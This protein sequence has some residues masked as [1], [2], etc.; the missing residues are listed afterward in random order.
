MSKSRQNNWKRQLYCFLFLLVMGSI[1]SISILTYLKS[2]QEQRRKFSEQNQQLLAQLADNLN[3]YFDDLLRFS[4]VP[5][6]NK[7]LINM[8]EQETKVEA[9]YRLEKQRII[10]DFLDTMMVYP[11]E[12][13]Q[14]VLLIADQVYYGSRYR[15]GFKVSFSISDMDESLLKQLSREGSAFFL[16][17]Y[18]S[19]LSSGASIEIVSLYNVVYSAINPRKMLAI[20]R[21][22]ADFS[23]IDRACSSIRIGKNS[24]VVI[25]GDEGKIAFSSAPKSVTAALPLQV[26]NFTA[27]G[28]IQ[29]AGGDYLINYVEITKP[30]WTAY[31]VTSLRD[32]NADA[33]STRNLMLASALILATITL[34]AIVLSL[35]RFLVPLS[36]IMIRIR[37]VG[38]GNFRVRFPDKRDDEIGMLGRTMNDVVGRLDQIVKKNAALE[39]RVLQSQL[40]EREAQV[41][42]LYS[43]IQPHFLY[44]TLN[45]ISMSVQMNRNNEAVV[46][47]HKLVKLMRSMTK[48][49]SLHP[50]RSEIQLVQDYLDIQKKRYG[51]R[52]DYKLEIEEAALESLVPVLILQPIVENAIVHGCEYGLYNI[53]ISIV[54]TC[55]DNELQIQITDNGPGIDAETLREVKKRMELLHSEDIVDTY[56]EGK[57]GL[58]NVNCRLKIRYGDKFGVKI[59]SQPGRGTTVMLRVPVVMKGDEKL[60]VSDFNC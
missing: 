7:I 45:T 35:N 50:I 19:D 44:N 40:V 20:I 21:V 53:M 30:G 27:P 47:L 43:Q 25:L 2:S 46:I 10:E 52:L 15:L 37:E 41:N 16:G 49:D 56:H 34:L 18:E 33:A 31:T 8:L 13:I 36:E 23:A 28:T 26:G 38:E 59:E 55:S 48:S 42:M 4:L 32:I 12:D 54:L 14:N 57:T 24:G 29:L 22:D 58:R 60:I 1:C 11:R 5:A 3:G 51:K 9:V 6:Y 39:N 17:P